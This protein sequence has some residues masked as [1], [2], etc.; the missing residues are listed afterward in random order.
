MDTGLTIQQVAHQTGLSIDTL[1]YYERIGLL[2]QVGR[3]ESG[4]RR[5]TSRDLAWI[6]L[7]IRLRDTGMPLAQMVQFA[8]L[9]RQGDATL[10]ERR[11][12]LEQHQ[13]ALEARMRTTEQHMAAL[14]RKI[15]SLKAREGQQDAASLPR[16]PSIHRVAKSIQSEGDDRASDP[17]IA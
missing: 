15:A 3:T 8:R 6:D 10:A 7:L 14:Q 17:E 2:E 5:Y 4:H 16:H 11:L 13:R 9:R 1:R 12:M